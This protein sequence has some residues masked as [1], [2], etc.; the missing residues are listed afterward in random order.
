M[1]TTTTKEQ[2]RWRELAADPVLQDRPYKIETNARG[3]LILSPRSNRHSRLRKALLNRLDRHAPEGESFPA[4]ALATSQGVKVLDVVWMSRARAA[5]MQDTGD[6]SMLAPEI[7]VE[8][9]SESNTVEEMTETRVLYR[10]AGAEEVWLVEHNGRIRFFGEEEMK[11]SAI[12]PECPA[13]V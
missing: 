13:R 3:Q 8:V 11:H 4:Y 2:E 1:P 6:P 5:A 12:A 7:C 9:L 10:E